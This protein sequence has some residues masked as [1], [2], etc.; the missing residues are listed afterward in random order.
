MDDMDWP[1]PTAADVPAEPAGLTRFERVREVLRLEGLADAAKSRAFEHRR[2]LE[3]DARA[4]LAREKVAPTWRITDVGTITLPTTQ[5]GFAVTDA[6][7]LLAWC[8]ERHPEQVETVELVRSAFVA[9]L[10]KRAT[11]AGDLVVDVTGEP[12]PGL[13]WKVGGEAKSLSFRIES[14]VKKLFRAAADEL[15]D[16]PDGE[17]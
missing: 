14:D 7:A 11:V 13:A 12:V 6:A 2:A 5:A 17:R 4:E 1:E 3:A 16:R 15:L 9:A 8:Q 10:M